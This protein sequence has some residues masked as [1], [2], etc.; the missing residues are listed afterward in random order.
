MRVLC[1]APGP[2]AGDGMFGQE[3]RTT[4]VLKVDPEYQDCEATTTRP[5][6]C[7][8]RENESR[9]PLLLTHCCLGEESDAHGAGKL[10][11]YDLSKA[12]LVVVDSCRKQ[13]L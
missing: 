4:M 2:S 6:N 8:V 5:A 12:K 3:S 13:A 10:A 1:C 11:V 9:G 7:R